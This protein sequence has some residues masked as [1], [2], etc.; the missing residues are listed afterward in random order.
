MFRYAVIAS[1]V[2]LTL[3]S[4]QAE[5]YSST[6]SSEEQERHEFFDVQQGDFP[7]GRLSGSTGTYGTSRAGVPVIVQPANPYIGIL[8]NSLND[9]PVLMTTPRRVSGKAAGFRPLPFPIR[10]RPG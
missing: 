1:T 5:P 3:S 10:K 8:P 2:L 4:V 7:S 9:K 6:L